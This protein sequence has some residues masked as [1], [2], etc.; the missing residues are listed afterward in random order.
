MDLY[1][2]LPSSSLILLSEYSSLLDCV[3]E[4]NVSV[5]DFLTLKPS[6]LT[7]LV[8]RSVNEIVKFQRILK[9]EFKKHVLGQDTPT[10]WYDIASE[11]QPLAFTTADRQI[12]KI[13]GGGIRTHGITEIFGNSSTG[14][15]QLLMQLSLSV[16][17]P[18]EQGG[19]NG[20]CVFVTTEGDLTTQ[21]IDELLRTKEEFAKFDN[22]SQKNIFTVSCCD[23]ANQEHILNVQLPI[24]LERNRDVKLVIID[25]ISHHVR[26]ELQRKTFRDSQDN[27]NYIDKMA[28]NLLKLATGH[29]IAIVVANQV[30][31]KPL[32]ERSV[33]S[34]QYSLGIMDHDYQVGWTI[35]W[36]DSSIFYRQRLVGTSMKSFRTQRNSKIEDILSD[37]EDSNLVA[38][39]TFLL[40][41]RSQSSDDSKPKNTENTSK[42]SRL[43]TSGNLVGK[44]PFKLPTFPIFRNKRK[45][46]SKVPNLGLTWAN[47]LTTRILLSKTYK[48]SPMIRTGN[49][50]LNKINDTANF[51][52]AKRTLKVVFSSYS[53]PDEIDYM[54][55]RK[56]IQSVAQ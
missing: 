46:D 22:V 5:V 21:R 39:A 16:Q 56:G 13:L 50:D 40:T 36:R 41:A 17:L 53:K 38:Q 55:K 28:Q 32:P 35:G 42:S 8:P 11:Q 43:N 6:E 24:L 48:A 47:H 7:K 2:Q 3:K 1:D 31:D 15:S 45:V 29:S 27:R 34:E 37:D 52:Q 20:K 44:D 18:E 14:K 54:I 4:N 33:L 23:L 26:V 49:P 9:E 30:G 12:D 51:W 10:T 19:L 25:S